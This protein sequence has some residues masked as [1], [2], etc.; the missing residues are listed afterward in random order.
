M[1]VTRRLASI[2][3]ALLGVSTY[4]KPAQAGPDLGDSQV[5]AIRSA[6]GGQ[7]QGLPSTKL[8]WYLADLEVAQ[9][10]ADAG[11]LQLP[12]QLAIAMRR[13]GT[14]R[15]LMGTRCAGL[16]RL[17]KK[18]YGD[19]EVADTL[20]SRNGSRAV[21]DEMFPPAELAALLEDGIE[22]GIGVAELLPVEGREYPVM[23][24][25]DPQFLQYRW[26]ENRWYFLSIAG[27]LPITPGDGRW[28]LHMPGARMSPWNFGLWPALGRSFINKEHAMLHRS[29]YS[30]KLANPARVAVSPQGASEAQKQSWFKQVMAWGLN[31]IFGMTPGYDVKL[32]ESN[33]RGFDVFAKEIDTSDLEMMVAIAGNIVTTTGGA[34][35]QNSDIHRRIREDLIKSDGD[36]LA[37]TINTQG[38][39][40]YIASSFGGEEALATRW[41]NVEWDTATPKELESE[42]RTLLAVAQAIAQLAASLQGS[43]RQLDLDELAVRFGLP[44]EQADRSTAE[45]PVAEAVAKPGPAKALSN[46]VRLLPPAA[47]H[48]SIEQLA[49]LTKRAA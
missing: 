5:A 26:N 23:V 20:R 6:L 37:Y 9:A 10:N 40:Y 30:A 46:L 38:L 36:A 42:S 16:V 18:F 3:A 11:H 7:I 45:L 35:F 32:L 14:L 43:D 8:R 34:G 44:L 41:V 48:M 29:N 21:F 28:I 12:A 13:D 2:V 15:G 31:S 49:E 17:P 24:R 47:R 4:Q 19:T 22:L 25:L 39:P 33:G 1:A 27:P